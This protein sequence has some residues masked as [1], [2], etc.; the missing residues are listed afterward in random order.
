MAPQSD[1][2]GKVS[3]AEPRLLLATRN[4]GKA[5][6]LADLFR[7]SGYRLVT[8]DELGI[9]EEIEET[10][11]SYLENARLKAAGYARL[12]RLL[13]AADDSGIEA[14]A[15]DGAPG[16]GSARYGGPELDDAGRNALLASEIES[17]GRGERGL[18]FRCVVVIADADGELAHFEGIVQGVLA[19]RAAGENGFGYDPIFYLPERGCTTA[20]LPPEEKHRIS[21]RGKAVAAAVDW[22]RKRSGNRRSAATSGLES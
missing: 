8:L 22:L 9:D 6:E 5:R 12:S 1:P 10:G 20:E 4:P 3:A 13:T 15:L 21:H 11:S 18:A 19:D 14:D 17:S 2:G 7:D 16:H